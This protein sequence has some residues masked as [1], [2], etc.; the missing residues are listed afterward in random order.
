MNTGRWEE[1]S[2]PVW[3]AGDAK[4]VDLEVN[5]ESLNTCW[6][7]SEQNPVEV[8]LVA[9][10]QEQVI[11]HNPKRGKRHRLWQEKGREKVYIIFNSVC[12][13]VCVGGIFY[14]LLT[15]YDQS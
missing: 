9:C 10:S 15:P 14:I 2:G 5:T 8:T 7:Q 3:G 13:C 11:S 12:V 1:G 4:E 6:R